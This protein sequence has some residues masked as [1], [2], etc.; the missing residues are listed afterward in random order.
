VFDAELLRFIEDGR[1]AAEFRAGDAA[2]VNPGVRHTVRADRGVPV[3]SVDGP[4]PPD[5]ALLRAST[6]HHLSL[7]DAGQAEAGAS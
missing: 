5:R 4:T 1:L 2:Y 7:T 6:A 3:I